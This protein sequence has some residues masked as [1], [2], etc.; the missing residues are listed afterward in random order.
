[1]ACGCLLTAGLR[2]GPTEALQVLLL[3][4]LLLVLFIVVRLLRWELLLLRWH[5][6]IVFVKRLLLPATVAL[7]LV[8]LIVSSMFLVLV[9]SAALHRPLVLTTTCGTHL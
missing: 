8:E 9:V 3:V 7:V 4:L 1:M 6:T 5:A 2:S